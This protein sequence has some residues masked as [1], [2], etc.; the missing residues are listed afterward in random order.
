MT[1][2]LVLVATL[3][4][5]VA[6]AVSAPALA[7]GRLLYVRNVSSLDNAAVIDAL[8]AFQ[9]AIDEDFEP[10]WSARVE[11][12]FI[13]RDL[14]P[15]NGW[16]IVLVDSPEC[17]LCSGFHHAPK[18]VPRA[19][20]GVLADDPREWQGTFTHEVFELIVDPMI[21]R[22]VLV[23]K[24]W[25]ALEVC[26]PVE[27]NAFAYERS[28][29]SGQ[30]VRISDFLTENWFRPHSRGPYDFTRHTK[31]PLQ[32]LSGGY[33]L[34]WTGAAWYYERPSGRPE[35]LPV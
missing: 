4:A 8:P 3:V 29:A 16:R 25:F 7:G 11:L 23:G 26:D 13:G 33:Q 12:R 19:E 15:A 32:V 20:V 31:R 5:L 9:A 24:K 10:V 30:P 17:W 22:G 27:D 18:G 21:N 28:S 35:R 14:P 34:I 2:R 6:L 1:R